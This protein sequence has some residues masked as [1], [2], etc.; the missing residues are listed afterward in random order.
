[1]IKD[2]RQ[3]RSVT[4]SPDLKPECLGSNSIYFTTIDVPMRESSN[5]LHL[6]FLIYKNRGDNNFNFGT[7]T[8]NVQ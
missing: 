3:S 2:E 8:I 6:S 4:K 5:F 1:M 7:G